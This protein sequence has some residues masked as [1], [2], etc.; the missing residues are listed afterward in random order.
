MSSKKFTRKIDRMNND[1]CYRLVQKYY[2]WQEGAGKRWMDMHLLR[3]LSKRLFYLVILIF[4]FNK[5]PH[6]T[7][8]GGSIKSF[9]HQLIGLRH[10]QKA[11]IPQKQAFYL[12]LEF[13]SFDAPAVTIVVA[14]FNQ[15]RFTYKCL[16][17]ILKNTREVQ[18]KVIVVDDGSA[19]ETMACLQE[20]KNI[21]L[22]RNDQNMGFLR[23]CNKAAAL[24]TTKYICF[25]N[26]D[27]IVGHRWLYHLINVFNM[28][29]DAGVVGAKLVYPYGLLQEAGGLVNA[30]GAPANFGRWT[31]SG[32]LKYNYL[33]ETDYCSG[34]CILI[35]KQDFFA[36]NGFNEKYAPAYYEDTDLCFAVRFR[37]RK[38]VF[39]QPLAEVIHFEGISSGKRPENGNA[40][41][42]Q[43]RNAVTFVNE[44]KS[45]FSYFSD[46]R[47]FNDQVDKFS[48][49]KK[50]ILIIDGTL[51][52]YDKDSGSRRM[53]E[54]IKIFFMLDFEVYFMAENRGGEDPYYSELVT[55]GVRM[56]Y[57]PQSLRSKEELLNEVLPRINYAWI[58]RP[59][60]NEAYSPL[61]RKYK[62]ITWIYDT[63]DLH[64]LRLERSLV[65]DQSQGTRS[66]IEELKQKELSFAR[67]ADVTIVVTPSEKDILMD[68][69]AKN[70]RVIPN[71][72]PVKERAGLPAFEDREG[73]C[74]IGSYEHLPNVDAVLWLVGEIMPL[75]WKRAPDMKITLLGSNPPPEV[76]ALKSDRI[77]VPG[78]LHDVSVYFQNSRLFVAPLRYGAGMKGKIGQAMEYGLPIVSTDIGIEGMGLVINRD[79][80]LANTVETFAAE[81]LDLYS[82]KERWEG[83]ARHS[84]E[85]ISKYAPEVVR[86]LVKQAIL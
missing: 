27:T 58:A 22:L 42:Y 24:A 15:W 16:E 53:N 56:V 6:R 85:S 34:A 62:G 60:L 84:A 21:T 1:V 5:Y 69:G 38:K 14:V 31:N 37:L 54:L 40:K 19:D 18:Y 52:L 23:S 76:L 32:D 61:I 29:D 25:L 36:L 68:A 26:N 55:W 57:E 75:I 72:H 11:E 13:P 65:Y 4:R 47:D 70:V 12:P 82:N 39:Y 33:R 35:E 71:V 74:F 48:R 73:I 49:E 2:L 8:N 67:E 3:L 30:T 45:F 7:K 66:G 50:K 9:I 86:D 80:A 59:H 46:S 77:T 28:H 20:C 79:V 63:V 81:V 83:I 78:Y 64:Y 43:V 51:P 17:S 44:W 41:S 10:F